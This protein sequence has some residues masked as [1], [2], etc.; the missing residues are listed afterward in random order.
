MS[1]KRRE[2][3]ERLVTSVTGGALGLCCVSSA[4]AGATKSQPTPAS[5][6]QRACLVDTTLCIGCRA[7]EKA[8]NQRNALPPPSQPFSSQWVFREQR[9][10]TEAAFTVVN[11]FE[12]P[13]S[14]RQK[15]RERTFVKL[16]CMHCLDPACVSA[17][18]VGALKKTADGSVLYDAHKCIGC[19]Y[20][21]VACPF[22]IPAYEYHEPLK[23]RVRKC[24]FCADKPKGRAVVQQP[25]CA[26]ACPNEA[27]T[28]G[29]REEL[30]T[31]AHKRIRRRPERY[32][33]HVYG[34][35]EV[36]GTSWL[37]LAGRPLSGIS[38][39]PLSQKAPPRLT[40]AIQHGIFR[41]GAA[42]L[43][44]YGS[45]AALMWINSRRAS[46]KEANDE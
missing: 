40:E 41:Y 29:T 25:A 2:F 39:L 46:K 1:T 16:Q 6:K 44:V 24:T 11:A 32:I 23:P 28:L 21:M 37:Y 7:C 14:A 45:L 35:K 3:L 19:R 22:E 4:R 17:C 20:C 33:P 13:P 42:P 27:L 36:G 31:L 18:I 34:E 5:Q 43:A 26:A 9:R 10:P 38:L 12:G 8:C 15:D 30:L